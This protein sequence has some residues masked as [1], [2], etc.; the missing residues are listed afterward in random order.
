MTIPSLG[1]R[2]PS[3][4]RAKLWP[5][6]RRGRER[7]AV[8]ARN[9]TLASAGISVPLSLVESDP[10]LLHLAAEDLCWQLAVDDLDRRRPRRGDRGAQRAW[11]A[12]KASLEAQGQRLADMVAE[13]VSA[14]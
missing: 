10:I 8:L 12:E 9:L 2:V 14:L 6:T 7:A 13:T 1:T 5:L 11:A 4:R 3:P